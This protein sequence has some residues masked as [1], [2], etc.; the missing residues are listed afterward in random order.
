MS[1]APS[2]RTQMH[3]ETV[4]L[5][6]APCVRLARSSYERRPEMETREP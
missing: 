3:A 6:S 5:P 4:C 1:D 2:W